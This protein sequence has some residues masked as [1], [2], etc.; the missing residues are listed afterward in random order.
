MS[1]RSAQRLRQAETL[2]AVGGPGGSAAFMALHRSRSCRS[3]RFVS[4]I[5]SAGFV[6]ERRF[7]EERVGQ[8][9]VVDGVQGVEGSGGAEHEAAHA[10]DPVGQ[11]WSKTVG[12]DS[13]NQ[14][15]L[16]GGEQ[17]VVLHLGD[18]RG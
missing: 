13:P 11:S 16:V 4:K 3:V 12:L 14:I 7:K 10:Y 1:V 6:G 18:D 15:V 9:R 2:D 8:G 5:I 17:L